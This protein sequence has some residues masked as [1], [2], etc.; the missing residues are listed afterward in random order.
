MKICDVC[1]KRKDNLHEY[2]PIFDLPELDGVEDICH[3]CL[4]HIAGISDEVQRKYRMKYADQI[5]KE[6]TEGIE[7]FLKTQITTDVSD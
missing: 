7:R 2:K 3:D 6:T 1:K 4:E 5:A